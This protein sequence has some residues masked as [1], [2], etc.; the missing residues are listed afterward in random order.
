[1]V[2]KPQN[3]ISANIVSSGMKPGHNAT[4]D[5]VAEMT[6]MWVTGVEMMR[7]ELIKYSDANKDD[8]R[9]RSGII[10]FGKIIDELNGV[11]ADME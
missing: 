9:I 2:Y 10:R 8:T 5:Q 1:M 7:K 3:Q 11:I 4:H 6:K